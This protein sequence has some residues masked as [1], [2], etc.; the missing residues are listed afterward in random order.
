V[1]DTAITQQKSMAASLKSR[2]AVMGHSVRGWLYE[3]PRTLVFLIVA[4]ILA[5]FV[6]YPLGILFY[7]SLFD[8]ETQTWT[9]A[10]YARFFTEPSLARAFMTTLKLAFYTSIVCL[11]IALPMAWAVTRTNMPGRSLVRSLVVLTFATPSFLGAIGWIVL[12]GPNAG[13]LNDLVKWMFGLDS[14]VFNI[15]TFEG[16][17]F[18]LSLYVYPFL[19]FSVSS[20]LDNMDP[21]MEQAARILG[22]SNLRVIM[23]VTLPVVTPAILSGLVLVI[24]ESFVIFGAPAVLGAP[25]FIHT[26]STT[27]HLL[28]TA[29]PPQFDMAATAATP[30]L[31]V[32][33]ILLLFQRLYLGRKNYVT[34]RGV[35]TQPEL[36]DVGRWRYVLAFFCI[37]VVVVGV[38]LPWL[39]LFQASIVKIWGLPITWANLTYMHYVDLFTDNELVLRAFGNSF[40]LALSA[41]MIAV[42]FNFVIAWIVERTSVPGRET[43]AFLAMLPLSFPGVALGMALVL[44]FSAPP[45]NLYGTLWLFVIAYAVKGTPFAFMFARSSLKQIHEELEQ[46]SRALGAGWFKTIREITLPLVKKGLLSVGTILFAQKFRDAQTSVMLY[47][48]GLEVVSI[49]ILDFVEEAEFSTL[50]AM[51][52]LVLTVNLSLVIISRRF[53]GKASFEL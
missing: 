5:F 30:I 53:V 29:D 15:Y 45:F 17:V 26:L 48:G 32:T 4:L 46:S 8:F 10:N 25:K 40:K 3:W 52:F 47:V 21:G 36:V 18:V 43:L 44:A 31:M 27:V 51:A 16:M 24:L 23:T 49:L 33:T 6:L 1:E 19:F 38:G 34:V 2:A 41:A 7:R 28:F 13:I 9:L 42:M 37:G 50:G 22:A 35:A 12:M 11:F 20:A 14:N 39:A